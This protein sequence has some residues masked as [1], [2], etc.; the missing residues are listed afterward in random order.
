MNYS[1]L[2]EQAM[3]HHRAG[4][5]DEAVEF[6]DR[7]LAVQP[8]HVDALNLAGAIAYQQGD[9][10]RAL[11]LLGRAVVLAETR[12]E[13]HYHL[14]LVLLRQRKLE[15]AAA[16]FRKAVE[17]S[18]TLATAHRHLAE[19]L[20]TLGRAQEAVPVFEKALTFAPG[21]ADLLG[22]IGDAWQM[23]D[24]LPQAIAAYQQ[25]VALKPTMVQA[26]WGL[27]CAE[28]TR[29]D[30]AC[31]AE[32]FRRVIQLAP[33]HGMAYHN[34]GKALFELGQI[35]PALDAFRAAASNLDGHE[36][37][38]GMIATAIPGSPRADQ[39]AILEARQTWASRC[40]PPGAVQTFTRPSTP[41]DRRLRIGYVSAFFQDPNWM[42]PVW[43]LVNHHDRTRFEIH[44]FSDAPASSTQYAYA[45]DPRDRFHDISRLTNAETARLIEEQAMDILV[46]LNAYSRLS[47]LALFAMRPA[48]LQVAWFNMYATSG[49]DCFDYLI[50]DHH[51]FVSGEEAFYTERVVCA[52]G[53]YL[54][55]EVTYPVPEVAPPPC[56]ERG[57]FTFG[58][59]APLYKITTEVVEAWS[60]ILHGSPGS[61]LILKNVA[62]ASA[63]NREWVRNL[64]AR[65]GVPA[66]R[67]EL[68]GPAP[69]FE[70]LKKYG[71]I[72]LALDT[73]PYN[74]GT[75]TMEAIWQGVPV[76]TFDG[77]RWASR[78]SASLLRNAQMPEFVAPD[79]DG[80]V[81]RAIELARARDQ[82][83]ERRRRGR[84][85]L[86]LTPVCD[87]GAFAKDMERAYSHM[88]EA[89]C[90]GCG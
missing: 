57:F 53:C 45:R 79:L 48:P 18:P 77:D 21:D 6:Y 46:D 43:G 4:R 39:R 7:I 42:K 19:V 5:L 24:K 27:A 81:N 87:T 72:D 58:C 74:G 1:K 59:L 33:H 30:Y 60:R 11:E 75:T 84:A 32:S 41:M 66:E 78:I 65:F 23:L 28:S 2:L 80:Y 26:W 55:F 8:D 83:A 76:L 13:P 22:G 54:T 67:V 70:F 25:A 44:L 35:D 85:Q 20:L 38:L 31:A 50:G 9:D 49:L 90:G 71:D 73:F 16:R 14:G 62:F 47:R 68:D 17:L 10:A 64:F 56:R 63:A 52:P 15:A 69:H 36:M 37:P 34:L 40:I 61:R 86:A 88:W 89:W 12:A 29:Q 3:A 82:L 51:V